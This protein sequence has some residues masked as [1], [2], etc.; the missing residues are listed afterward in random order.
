M[1]VGDWDEERREEESR[2][3][4]VE[5]SQTLKVLAFVLTPLLFRQ[6]GA[7]LV[8]RWLARL[9]GRYAF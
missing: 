7:V 9:F 3:A 2:A 6:V 4:L 5:V 8:R 1:E